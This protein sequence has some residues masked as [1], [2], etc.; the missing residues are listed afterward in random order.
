MVLKL[1]L[2]GQNDN[3][4]VPGTMAL[5]A[6]LIFRILAVK[7]DANS[8][9]AMPDR[10]SEAIGTGGFFWPVDSSKQSACIIIILGDNV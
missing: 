8:L 2:D 1:V 3:I 7:N 6:S 4:P 5:T 9:Q 10:C